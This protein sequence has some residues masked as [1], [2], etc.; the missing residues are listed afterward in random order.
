MRLTRIVLAVT[1]CPPVITAGIVTGLVRAH[2][3]HWT[4]FDHEE[5]GAYMAGVFDEEDRGDQAMMRRAA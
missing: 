3:R 5:L 2:L 4:N 1:L